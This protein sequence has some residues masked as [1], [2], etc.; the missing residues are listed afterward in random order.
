ME[1]VFIFLLF[2][3]KGHVIE[4]GGFKT[5]RECHVERVEI[6]KDAPEYYKTSRCVKV[7]K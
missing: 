5:E 1:V 4:V 2:T 3:E 6:L 7:W